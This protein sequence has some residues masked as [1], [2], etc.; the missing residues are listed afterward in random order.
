MLADIY[1]VP[2]AGSGAVANRPTP[3]SHGSR[4]SG[5]RDVQQ[6]RSLVAV[7][8]YGST[9]AAVGRRPAMYSLLSSSTYFNR[10]SEPFRRLN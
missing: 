6:T 3:W 2:S 8:M 4:V 9:A 10:V 1:T 5:R 7:A